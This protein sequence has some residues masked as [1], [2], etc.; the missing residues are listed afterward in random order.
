MFLLSNSS[1]FL[2]PAITTHLLTSCSARARESAAAINLAHI[3]PS[4]SPVY[5]PLVEVNLAAVPWY[6][7]PD[8]GDG[9]CVAVYLYGRG[10]GVR[11]QQGYNSSVVCGGLAKHVWDHT[12][13]FLRGLRSCDSVFLSSAWTLLK[14][15]LTNTCTHT[16]T[17]AWQHTRPQGQGH[18]KK[19][20]VV[21]P[22]KTVQICQINIQYIILFFPLRQT[23]CSLLKWFWSI[24]SSFSRGYVIALQLL[25]TSY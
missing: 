22:V 11:L 25:V 5:L 9:V 18:R 14:C 13:V 2:H 21:L 15:V 1:L 17:N 6:S 23:F 4:G 19:S 24:S 8:R 12:A 16:Y 20:E 3:P 10:A 7:K